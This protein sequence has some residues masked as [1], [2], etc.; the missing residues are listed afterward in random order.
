[1]KQNIIRDEISL[2]ISEQNN[3]FEEELKKFELLQR[4]ACLLSNS[5]IVPQEYRA[6]IEKKVEY[7]KKILE[8]NPNAISNC[9]IAIDMAQRMNTSELMIMQNLSII[10]GHPSWSS[11]WI[12]AAINNCGK[13]GTLKFETKQLGEKVIPFEENY[14]DKDIQNKNIQKIRRSNITIQDMSCIAYATDKSTGERLESSTITIE[15]AV[16]E[17]WYT[18][19]GSKWKT[20]PEIMLKYRSASFFGKIY[21]PELLMGISSIEE[22]QD[23]VDLSS[24]YKNA[25]NVV[26]NEQTNPNA[27]FSPK[28][29][30]EELKTQTPIIN[31]SG[32][33][34]ENILDESNFVDE[35]K[36]ILDESNFIDEMKDIEL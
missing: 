31:I 2:P 21:A 29:I 15:M 11:Q 14:W 22:N 30:T 36:D 24:K 17:G 6:T 9:A 3:K 26:E 10:H 5:T 35:I 13:Y 19:P 12:I 27:K 34:I 18:K 32:G 33:E 25:I 4:K 28:K 1:M 20:M 7:G 8:N 23:I 16:M